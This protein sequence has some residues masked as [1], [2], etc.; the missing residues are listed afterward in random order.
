[1]SDVGGQDADSRVRL[2]AFEFLDATTR[3]HGRSL[4][5]KVLSEGFEFDGH[6]VPLVGPQDIFKP[7]VLRDMPLSIA[8]TPPVPGKTAPYDDQLGPDGLLRYRHRGTDPR[9]PDNGLRLAMQYKAPLVYL[10]G[11]VKGFYVAER[12][13]FIVGDDPGSPTFTVAVGKE[14]L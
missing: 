1:V 4:P 8:T 5:W 7:A 14:G 2:A 13:V 6:R 3:L 9:H 12:P 11:V 10:H